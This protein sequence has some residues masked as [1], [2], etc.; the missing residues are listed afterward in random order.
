MSKPKRIVEIELEHRLYEPRTI[1]KI[2]RQVQHG[3]G[4]GYE[5]H[6]YTPSYRRLS[7][8]A[9]HINGMIEENIGEIEIKANPRDLS[10]LFKQY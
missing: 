8:F 1:V 9:A 7:D 2:T 3:P 4:A 10:V 6:E 5:E